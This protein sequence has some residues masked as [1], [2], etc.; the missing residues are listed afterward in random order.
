MKFA[1]YVKLLGKFARLLQKSNKFKWSYECEASFQ[2]LKKR[3]ISS[4]ILP[5]PKGN[6]GFVIYSNTSKKGLGYVLMKKDQ[7]ITYA[8]HQVKPYEQNYPTHD[9]KL[10]A[11]VFV[12]KM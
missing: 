4:P 10:A 6:E 7:L 11:V 5:L 1:Q 8:S 9:L 2:E 12:L 3:S